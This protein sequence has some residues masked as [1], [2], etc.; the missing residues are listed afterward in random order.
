MTVLTPR[1]GRHLYFKGSLPPTQGKLAA[2]IDTR[3]ENS[4]VVAPGSVIDGKMYEVLN[5]RE[6]V[7]VPVLLLSDSRDDEGAKPRPAPLVQSFIPQDT[8]AQIREAFRV[9]A[10]EPPCIEGSATSGE[11]LFVVFCKMRDA[12]LSQEMAAEMVAGSY[13][14]KCDPPW[15]LSDSEHRRHFY[16]KLQNAYRYA[17]NAPGASSP[18]AKLQRAKIDFNRVPREKK[19]GVYLGSKMMNRIT[20]EQFIIEGLAAPGTVTVIGGEAGKGKSLFAMAVCVAAASGKKEILGE[21]FAIKRPVVACYLD[22]ED[23]MGTNNNRITALGRR[24]ELTEA[25]LQR[26]VVVDPDHARKL[27]LVDSIRGT[28]VVNTE[29]VAAVKDV[30]REY[31]VELLTV[32][33]LSGLTTCSDSDNAGMRKFMNVLQ[34]IAL[35]TG[36]AIIVIHHTSK[37]AANRNTRDGI[38]LMGMYRGASSI[39]DAS[40]LAWLLLAPDTD[41]LRKVGLSGE[42]WSYF[43][44]AQAKNNM[45]SYNSRVE[46]F[47]KDIIDL[48]LTVSA[49]AV[50]PIEGNFKLKGLRV[51]RVDDQKQ[52]ETPA[53]LEP[54]EFTAKELKGGELTVDRLAEICPVSIELRALPPLPGITPAEQRQR[55]KLIAY[56]QAIP[57]FDAWFSIE[58]SKPVR[59]IN[60]HGSE[61]KELL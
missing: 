18:E 57:A 50:S 53:T 52:V 28:P 27:C 61:L 37:A 8:P 48:S 51:V 31:G 46:V 10:L 13:N 29:G 55:E 22:Q 39:I 58:K 56:L 19:L 47:H 59:L 24:Y 40:R 38:G 60:K 34:E 1:G 32:A 6:P 30:I 2:K 20:E 36:C 33:P 14:E 25:E 16:S 15:D 35:E 4:Y 3:G 42:G 54:V 11:H 41:D 9:L 23:V 7:A 43:Y 5:E 45:S 21:R 49:P 26:V 44:L 17:Q 12:G